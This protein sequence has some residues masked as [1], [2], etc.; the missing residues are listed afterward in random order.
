MTYR[1]KRKPT[2][3]FII[4]PIKNIIVIMPTPSNDCGGFILVVTNLFHENGRFRYYN[5]V[6]TYL[7]LNFYFFLFGIEKFITLIN[8]N[9]NI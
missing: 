9:I 8:N 7:Q 2:I 5:G 6:P 4:G 3:L 1:I